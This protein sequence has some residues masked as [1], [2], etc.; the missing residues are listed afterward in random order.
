MREGKIAV[1]EFF[2]SP[3][4]RALSREVECGTGP[5]FCGKYDEKWANG[6]QVAKAF[7]FE[8]VFE[9]EAQYRRPAGK[10]TDR[11]AQT[12]EAPATSLAGR[13]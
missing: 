12:C 6:S 13:E 9:H 8:G 11:G 7:P 5:E 3:R 2:K 1:G 10:T 4:S